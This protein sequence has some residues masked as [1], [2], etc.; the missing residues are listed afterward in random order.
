MDESFS[1]KTIALF[2]GCAIVITLLIRSGLQ[3]SMAFYQIFLLIVFLGLVIAGHIYVW[4]KLRSKKGIVLVLYFIWAI[5]FIGIIFLKSM[6]LIEIFEIFVF[7][8]LIILG[9]IYIYLIH[10]ESPQNR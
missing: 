7:L 4:Q 6:A 5:I 1:K 9:Q 3:E 10:L 2:L 8:S